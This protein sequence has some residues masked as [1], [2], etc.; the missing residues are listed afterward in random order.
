MGHPLVSDLG[1]GVTTLRAAANL[2]AYF[3]PANLGI[4]PTLFFWFVTLQS[5]SRFE[6][7]V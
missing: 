3:L 5:S 2:V 6:T 1:S 7:V 4:M